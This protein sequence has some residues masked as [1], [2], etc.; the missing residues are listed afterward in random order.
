MI[1]FKRINAF[2]AVLELR[3]V[4][5]IGL[6]LVSLA[7]D[8]EITVV[9]DAVFLS[10]LHAAEIIAVLCVVSHEA[11]ALLVSVLRDL[12]FDVSA[13]T[14][15]RNPEWLG[16]EVGPH[17]LHIATDNRRDNKQIM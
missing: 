11:L 6:N 12:R 1:G 15:T 3:R 8:G 14:R 9:I 7:G 4:T 5:T 17:G 16:V 2:E 13:A 10:G